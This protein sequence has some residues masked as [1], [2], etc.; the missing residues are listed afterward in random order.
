VEQPQEI[1]SAIATFIRDRSKRRQLVQ[2]DEIPE[3]LDKQGFLMPEMSDQGTHLQP[4]IGEVLQE[5]EDLREISGTAGILYYYSTLSLSEAYAGLLV[6]KQEGPL[7][8]I[9]QTV[10]EN[11]TV[12]PRP[13]PLDLFG[14]PP[15][16]LTEQ[17]ILAALE[18]MGQQEQ[19]NDI[20][21]TM[22][23]IGTIFLFS[24]RHL[25]PDHASTL[26]EW[27]DVGQANNP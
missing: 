23:S 4:I 21:R 20:V 6:G 5:N 2:F 3:E 14:Q 26:A 18:E 8:L 19:Y 22:T 7:Q 27:L 9:A 25:D 24:N 13:V 1:H 17:E 11:S 15:F 12:Y 10:R 16:D